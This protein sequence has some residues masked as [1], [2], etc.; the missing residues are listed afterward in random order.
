M[1]TCS[2]LLL[3]TIRNL[4]ICCFSPPLFITLYQFP[5]RL[6]SLRLHHSIF[7]C[8]YCS[9]IFFLSLT[10][11]LP[12]S[13]LSLHAPPSLPPSQISIPVSLHASP[14]PSLHASPCF[15]PSLPASLLRPISSD[16]IASHDRRH[17]VKRS[18]AAMFVCDFF[19]DKN[20]SFRFF[21]WLGRGKVR[22]EQD[23]ES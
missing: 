2:S 23:D 14:S 21:L 1:F 5:N 11:Y 7:L 16:P 22:W 13:I 9:Y 12:F 8:F 20:S 10:F 3:L 19:E 4:T 6:V 18:A 15:P 17:F